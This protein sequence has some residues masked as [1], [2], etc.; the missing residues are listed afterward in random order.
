MP[1]QSKTQKLAKL[2]HACDE[3]DMS[4]I[5]Q[6]ATSPIQQGGWIC[7]ISWFPPKRLLNKKKPHSIH[8]QSYTYHM[9]LSIRTKKVRLETA[10]RSCVPISVGF[11]PG[12]V[13]TLGPKK[14]ITEIAAT[15][16]Q[17]AST[18]HFFFTVSN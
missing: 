7:C 13:S 3:H 1:K 6:T 17:Q 15:G 9:L 2:T 8:S 12:Q 16:I 18:R 10:L 11:C 4:W 14:G 5:P